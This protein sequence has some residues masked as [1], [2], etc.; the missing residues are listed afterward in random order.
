VY[1]VRMAAGGQSV[2]DITPAECETESGSRY[3]GSWQLV[4]SR[5]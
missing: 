3:W 2:P 4:F 5:P 1:Q